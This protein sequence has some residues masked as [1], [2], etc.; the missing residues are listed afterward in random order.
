MAGYSD[1]RLRLMREALSGQVTRAEHD[2][3]HGVDGCP[4]CK[5]HDRDDTGRHLRSCRRC[6]ALAENIYGATEVDR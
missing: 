1:D 5:L 3:R 4:V 6:V 2:H